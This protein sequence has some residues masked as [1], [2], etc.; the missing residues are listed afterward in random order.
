MCARILDLVRTSSFRPA[1][2]EQVE[3]DRILVYHA[4]GESSIREEDVLSAAL[5]PAVFKDYMLFKDEFG[6]VEGLPTRLYFV[7]PDIGE[8]FQVEIEQGKTLNLKVLA[9]GNLHPNGMREVFCEMNGQLRSV[10]VEDK[11]VTEVSH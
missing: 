2:Y 11:K 8:E 9:V 7:G 5:Y 6:P 1:R 10:M 4:A 3:S